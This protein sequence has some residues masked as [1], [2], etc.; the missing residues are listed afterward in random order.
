MVPG[1]LN[2]VI[3]A[4]KPLPKEIPDPLLSL[5]PEDEPAFA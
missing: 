4:G 5:S 2:K 3:F 1:K